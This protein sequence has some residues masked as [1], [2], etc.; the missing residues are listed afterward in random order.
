MNLGAV[1]GKEQGNKGEK[2][3]QALQLERLKNDDIT[4]HTLKETWK[5]V[6]VKWL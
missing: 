5:Q 4:C 6:P 3:I 1:L 2:L